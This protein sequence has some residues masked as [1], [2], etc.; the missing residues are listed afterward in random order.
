MILDDL[1]TEM[2]TTFSN[3]ALYSIINTRL[4]NEKKTIISTNYG[5][6]DLARKYTPQIMSRLEGEYLALPF[7]GRDIRLIRKELTE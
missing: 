5:D 4:I 3:S 6:E 7:I 2:V 1:G